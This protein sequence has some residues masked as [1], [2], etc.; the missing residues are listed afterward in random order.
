MLP[1]SASQ[2]LPVKEAL[3][4]SVKHSCTPLCLPWF[5]ATTNIM[6]STIDPNDAFITAP[7]ATDVW[8]ERLKN[9]HNK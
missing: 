8:A 5:K 2:Y 6:I 3:T 4:I 1:V 7:M 9:I